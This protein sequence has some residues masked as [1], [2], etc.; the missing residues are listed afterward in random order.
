MRYRWQLAKTSHKQNAQCSGN[1]KKSFE[2][3]WRLTVCY[4]Y[5]FDILVNFAF[6]FWYKPLTLYGE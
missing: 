2:T 1:T 3:N 6:K 4:F 5:F